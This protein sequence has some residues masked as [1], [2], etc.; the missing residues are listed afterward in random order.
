PKGWQNWSLSG[1]TGMEIYD[2]LDDVMDKKWKFPKYFFDILYSYRQ[3]S[4]ETFL[5][6]QDRPT[7]HL[8]KWDQLTQAQRIVGFAGN[9]AHQNVRVMGRL[10]DPYPLSFRFVTTHILAPQLD[11]ASVLSALKGG[12]AYIAFDMLSD[13]TGFLFDISNAGNQAM[14]GDELSFA[15]GQ[16]LK[17]RLPTPGLIVLIKDGQQFRQ[18]YCLQYSIPLEGPGVYRAEAFLHIQDR[19]RPWIFSN[20]IYVR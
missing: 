16:V 1:I 12:H 13:A 10:L 15:P 7:W 8:Q 4:A 2:V 11:E 19:W 20:P 6:I 5:S 14:M 9:D 3:Y 18:C 17:T